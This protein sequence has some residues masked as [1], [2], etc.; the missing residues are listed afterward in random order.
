[1]KTLLMIFVFTLIA[2]L[3]TQA[4]EQSSRIR[5]ART[6]VATGD[7]IK[8]LAILSGLK[9]E[10]IKFFADDEVEHICQQATEQHVRSL[11]VEEVAVFSQRPEAPCR[12]NQELTASIVHEDGRRLTTQGIERC[13]HGEYFAALGDFE[14]AMALPTSIN[15]ARDEL[16]LC[17]LDYSRS[18]LL[19]N[20]MEASLDQALRA[21]NSDVP[22]IRD[23]AGAQIVAV[24]RYTLKRYT[25]ANIWIKSWLLLQTMRDAV[26]EHV[27]SRLAMERVEGEFLIRAFTDHTPIREVIS[28]WMQAVY[29]PKFQTAEWKHGNFKLVNKM[30]HPVIVLLRGDDNLVRVS[31][32]ANQKK[33]VFVALGDYLV[34]V[35]HDDDSILVNRDL[36]ALV[37][38]ASDYEFQLGDEGEGKK[39]KLAEHS[40]VSG[41]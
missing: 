20:S 16:A 23:Q 12:L 7:S 35:Y 14:R 34:G 36:I 27:P 8:S 19:D 4:L 39:L 18:L 30:K 25:D 28:P 29:Q 37:N 22:V 13:Q 15:H 40:A 5:E 32:G 24:S 11:P 10:K 21:F 6:A 3:G 41:Q 2:Y 1:M 9:S 38:P 17:R 31:V 33:Q 26:Q